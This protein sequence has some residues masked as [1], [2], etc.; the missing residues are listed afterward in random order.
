MSDQQ[1]TAMDMPEWETYEMKEEESTMTFNVESTLWGI[2]LM[3][4]LA[5]GAAISSWYTNWI[6][7]ENALFPDDDEAN[8]ADE[9][10]AL[11]TNEVAAW[12]KLQDMTLYM[13]GFGF[14]SW[15]LN[16]SLGGNGGRIH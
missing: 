1:E 3:A 10:W 9:D 15:V 6:E 2:A 12:Q 5:T 13:Y 7:N 16:S 14:V 8:N 4:Q 11:A